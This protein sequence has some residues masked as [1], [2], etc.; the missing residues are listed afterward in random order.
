MSAV[1]YTLHPFQSARKFA[2][3]AGVN[4]AAAFARIREAQRHGEQGN[5][6]VG[7]LLQLTLH[8]RRTPPTLPG[9]A[10]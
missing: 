2:A 5:Q 10:A 4:D 9:G 6:V 1:I 8:R 3:R 7:E